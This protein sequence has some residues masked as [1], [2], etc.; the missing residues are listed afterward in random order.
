VNEDFSRFRDPVGKGPL[1]RRGDDLVNELGETFPIVNGIPRFVSRDNYA[2][3]FGAQWNRHPKT[4]LDS[5]SGITLT[6]DRL[7]RCMRGELSEV[8]GKRVLEFGCGAGRFTDVLLKPCADLD[9]FY[10]SAA[11]EANALNHGSSA[12]ALAQAD[13]RSMPFP[14][15]AMITSSASAFCSILPIPRRALPSSG[16][17]SRPAGAS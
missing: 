13:I 7:A 6:E 14:P 1:F 4:Q 10:Y 5:H 15:P 9:A 12:L 17:W 16:K 3:D 2:A 11:V 8:A